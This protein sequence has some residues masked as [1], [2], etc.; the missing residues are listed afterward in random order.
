MQQAAFTQSKRVQS[1]SVGLMLDQR[2]RMN[3]ETGRRAFLLMIVLVLAHAAL[4]SHQRR[5]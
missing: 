2:G 5:K 4:K 1:L 3:W